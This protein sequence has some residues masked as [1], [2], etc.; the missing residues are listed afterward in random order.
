[1]TEN[2]EHRLSQHDQG[3]FENSY[4]KS[5]LPV[6][7]IWQEGFVSHDDAFRREHQIKGWSRAK[8]EALIN[9]DWQKIQKLAKNRQPPG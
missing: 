4:T 2:I 8:K 1:M 5:R 9:G 3:Y 7:L 6:E